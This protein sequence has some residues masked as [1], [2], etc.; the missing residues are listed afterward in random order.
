[1]PAVIILHNAQTAYHVPVIAIGVAR[2]A[3]FTSNTTLSSTQESSTVPIRPHRSRW[4]WRQQPSSS[5]RPGERR[6]TPSGRRWCPS[7][8]GTWFETSSLTLTTGKDV[9][10]SASR[11]QNSLPLSPTSCRTTSVDECATGGCTGSTSQGHSSLIQTLLLGPA[12]VDTCSPKFTPFGTRA[13]EHY[14]Q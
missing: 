14:H 3:H 6:L 1:M 13:I 11:R 2:A 12:F 5:P 4:P 10:C 7:R 8:R 9:I